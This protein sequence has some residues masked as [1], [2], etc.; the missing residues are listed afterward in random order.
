MSKPAKFPDWGTSAPAN[1]I[2]DPGSAKQAQGWI[3]EAPPVQYFNWLLNLIGLWI[4]YFD[5]ELTSITAQSN[6]YDAIVGASGTHTSIQAAVD[7]VPAGG[8]I[9]VTENY[10]LADPVNISKNDLEIKIK[11]GVTISNQATARKGFIISSQRVRII[12]GKLQNFN[13]QVGDIAIELTATSKNCLI[14]QVYFFNNEIEIND[15]GTNNV[16]VG[17]IE[18][19]A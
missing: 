4:R 7:A 2:S 16:L 9:L 5:G 6:S 11:P 3:V 17:N 18:G 15:D 19:V 8:R 10:D 13:D 1:L 14:T 12:G